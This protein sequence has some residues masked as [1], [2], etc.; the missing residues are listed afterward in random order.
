[1]TTL[2]VGLPG[3][4]VSYCMA[5]AAKQHAETI[6]TLEE[7]DS[8]IAETEQQLQTL[9]RIFQKQP[10]QPEVP[11]ALNA[12]ALTP[13]KVYR[14]MQAFLAAFKIRRMELCTATDSR[15]VLEYELSQAVERQDYETASKLRDRLKELSMLK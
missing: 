9:E 10:K 11:E 12:I 3:G 13:M 1:M 14:Q 4:R 5:C 8:F 2:V 7:V 6:H 15:S